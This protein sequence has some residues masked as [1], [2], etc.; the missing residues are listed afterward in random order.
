MLVPTVG[1]FLLLMASCATYHSKPLKPAAFHAEFQDRSLMDP[2]LKK[3]IAQQPL[4]V[5]PGFPQVQDLST[6]VAAAWYYSP[7][8]RVQLAQLSV[9]QAN[10]ITA[11]QSPNPTVALSP[12]YLAKV[13]P[14]INPWILGFNFDIPIETAGRREDR[15]AQATALT[16]A[17]R[18]DLGQIAWN[19]RQGVRNTL[20]QYTFAQKRVRLL[21][22]QV[23]S[24]AMILSLIR[25]RFHAGNIS[26]PV[27]T[28][29][30]IQARQATLALVAAQ[31]QTRQRRI[32]LAGA[33]SLPVRALA[34][35]QLACRQIMKIPPMHALN[36]K[37]LSRAALLN[38]MDIQSLLAQY[39]AAEAALKL[40]IA[41]Q[42]PDIHLGPGYSF[43]Q[44]ANEFTLGFTM[45]LPIFNQNQG[46]IAAANAQRLVIA[47]EL[48][49]KQTTVIT[50]I[51][52][53]LS[54]YRSALRQ[55]RAAQ[56][57]ERQARMQLRATRR[58]FKA[59][60]KSR[61]AVVESQLTQ[62]TFAQDALQAKLSTVLALGNLEA[63]L[64]KPLGNTP[65]MPKGT[66]P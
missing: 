49:Q 17:G 65:A 12:N 15:M 8:L 31:G 47:D 34:K 40:Q 14:G 56:S 5:H 1:V 61:L 50:Q 19:V 52:A 23:Q 29:A 53:A 64:E 43:N 11:S 30:E 39:Q 59:G 9:D 22:Q 25:S 55:L 7:A 42:Y 35:V 60:A 3:F 38:R 66:T 6:L 48:K 27:Y 44:G 28:A 46:A 36:I 2:S 13:S 18:Y 41:R 26:R 24:T 32:E 37:R 4:K 45:A 54:Q 21:R 58:A 51:R 62:N 33:M 16:L 20:I 63:L 57:I 10:M